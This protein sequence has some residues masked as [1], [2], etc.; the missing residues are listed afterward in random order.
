[1]SLPRILST[2]LLFPVFYAPPSLIASEDPEWRLIAYQMPVTASPKSYAYRQHDLFEYFLSTSLAG[3]GRQDFMTVADDVKNNIT[4]HDNRG[5]NI[6]LEAFQRS[7]PFVGQVDL[8]GM[9]DI[10]LLIP[11][12]ESLW[13]GSR[14]NPE[15]DYG[16]WQLVR[17]VVEE[18]R[19]LDHAP[20]ALRAAHPDEIRSNADLS[21]RAAQIH[22]RRYYFYFAKVAGFAEN[23]A[24]L[25]AITAYNWGA[26]NV[27]R[28]LAEMEGEGMPLNFANFYQYLYANQ[29]KHP[30]DRS[31]RAAVEYLPSLW[32]IAQLIAEKG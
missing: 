5:G 20:Q 32:N 6:Y 8:Q 16:Y 1:M 31:I 22:L 28:L 23:D 21:T 13:D 24:W 27:K 14:G 9:P 7:W 18:I 25:L 26:G 12:M 4:W 2:V 11:Y 17:E 15:S 19:T 29:Q 10:I 30:A 3:Q